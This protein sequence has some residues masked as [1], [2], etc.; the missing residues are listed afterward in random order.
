MIR[1][2]TP[3]LE[4]TTDVDLSSCEELYITISQS[5][6][7]LIEKSIEDCI[8][9]NE[10]CTVTLTQEDTLKLDDKYPCYL[11]LR[12]K[13]PEGTVFAT[14]PPYELDVGKILKQGVI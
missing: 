14:Y 12:G 13:T 9:E 2:T 7:D 3:T 8:I 1:G 6:V 5:G 4:L 11:Q 10:K